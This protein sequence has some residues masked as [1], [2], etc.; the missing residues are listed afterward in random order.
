MKFVLVADTFSMSALM[1][2]LHIYSDHHQNLNNKTH[3]I[4]FC[5][6]S[7]ILYIPDDK[8]T[9]TLIITNYLQRQG[10]VF[11]TKSPTI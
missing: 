3:K 6:I 2:N 4:S 10:T 1:K 5:F 8:R 7:G 9:K 11:P